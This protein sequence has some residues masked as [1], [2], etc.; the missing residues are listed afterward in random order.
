MGVKKKKNLRESLS[1][2]I[3]VKNLIEI[4]EKILQQGSKNLP[5]PQASLLLTEYICSFIQSEA[6]ISSYL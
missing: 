1:Y 2:Y 5:N 6:Q 3:I 4:E